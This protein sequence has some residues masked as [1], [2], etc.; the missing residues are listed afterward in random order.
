M[1]DTPCQQRLL[2]Q[3]VAGPQAASFARELWTC[4]WNAELIHRKFGVPY[5]L[6]YLPV[7]L[8]SLG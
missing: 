5:H 2:K 6:Q 8:K 7:P 3:L 1:L 4:G